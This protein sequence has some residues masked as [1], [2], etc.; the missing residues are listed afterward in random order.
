MDNKGLTKEQVLKNSFWK[1]SE[2][3]GVQ[4]CQLVITIVLARLLTPHDY[5]LMAIIFVA[6]N[7]M[8]LFVTSSV[9]SYLVYIK[10]IKKEDFF[11]SW[12]L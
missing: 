4:V 7:F 9:S 10:D 5:G 3:I 1:F 8:S 2:G 11:Y 6:T 12:C